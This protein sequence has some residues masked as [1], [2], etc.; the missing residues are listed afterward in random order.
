MGLLSHQP[1]DLDVAQQSQQLVVQGQFG[2]G[3]EPFDP[4]QTLV[5]VV[6]QRLRRAL[7]GV[8]GVPSVV[9]L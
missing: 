7:G 3:A 4:I 1:N 8:T 6:G 9:E 2:L 5:N